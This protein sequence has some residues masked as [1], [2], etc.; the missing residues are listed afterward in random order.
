[1]TCPL[2][3]LGCGSRSSSRFFELLIFP[4]YTRG[5]QALEINRLIWNGK[6]RRWRSAGGARIK[7]IGINEQMDKHAG[8]WAS[9]HVPQKGCV[10]SIHHLFCYLCPTGFQKGLFF[11]N[12]LKMHL[13]FINLK[14]ANFGILSCHG[15]G[16]T[17]PGVTILVLS[18]QWSCEPGAR[19][20]REA[21]VQSQGP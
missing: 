7:T 13:S 14:V 8:G 21:A 3:F 20:C 1:M 12:I 19:L 11:L 9:L 2:S 15:A 16:W 10:Y 6:G 17:I 18:W 4:S 5:Y